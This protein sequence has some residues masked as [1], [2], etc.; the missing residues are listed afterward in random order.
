MFRAMFLILTCMLVWNLAPAAEEGDFIFFG[1]VTV[2][3]GKTVLIRNP[4][5]AEA[6]AKEC[7]EALDRFLKLERTFSATTDED[8]E[9]A[10]EWGND[11]GR[12]TDENL[13][14]YVAYFVTP[15]QEVRLTG[16]EVEPHDPT[17]GLMRGWTL[18][19]VHV[20]W[21][22]PE[23]TEACSITVE[24]YDDDSYKVVVV[25][26]DDEIKVGAN[27]ESPSG[28]KWE[29]V[30]IERTENQ[31]IINV[32]TDKGPEGHGFDFW[33]ATKEWPEPRRSIVWSEESEDGTKLIYPA[34][35]WANKDEELHSFEMRER[36]PELVKKWEV[37]NFA[38]KA[39]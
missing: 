17:M 12:L 2:R 35:C 16:A 19:V 26:E 3:D 33:I 23:T 29:I 4:E 13:V 18:G 7:E 11:G 14:P 6:E 32:E 9:L 21:W 5:L 37:K 34:S 38:L 24:Y 1:I 39:E 36:D 10:Y 15:G 30:S 27:G 31:A 22:A 28:V 20:G 25:L 8:G